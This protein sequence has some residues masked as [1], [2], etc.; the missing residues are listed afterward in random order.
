VHHPKNWKV[1]GKLCFETLSETRERGEVDIEAESRRLLASV[2]NRG[3]D[4]LAGAGNQIPC[5]D[6]CDTITILN[7]IL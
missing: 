5:S 3:F 1:Y 2:S 6:H 4:I 7:S